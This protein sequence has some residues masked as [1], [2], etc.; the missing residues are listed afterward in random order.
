MSLNRENSRWYLI[1]QHN[2]TL[3]Q[4]IIATETTGSIVG[5]IRIAW[6]YEYTTQPDVCNGKEGPLLSTVREWLFVVNAKGIVVIA[7]NSDSAST[8]YVIERPG[9]CAADMVYSESDSTLAVLDKR[10]YNIILLN[11]STQN[12]SNIS[13]TSILQEEVIAQLSRMTILQNQRI[14]V[15]VVTSVRRAV[16]LLIDYYSHKLITR[17]DLGQVRESASFESLTQLVYT[18][19]DDKH[20]F[21]TIAHQAV[22]LLTVQLN[23]KFEKKSL[24]LIFYF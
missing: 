8:E 19:I 13:L 4:A 18:Q 7:D 11:V 2:T 1:A 22:G 9:L 24:Y 5:R 6:V 10:T 20:L 15:L 3:A 17:F 12:V 16:L 14:L 23:S 21:V